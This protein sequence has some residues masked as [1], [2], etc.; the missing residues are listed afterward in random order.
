MWTN[1]ARII[2]NSWLR[3]GLKPRS[4]SRDLKWGIQVPLE[5]FT[6]KVSYQGVRGNLVPLEG[7]TDQE[8]FKR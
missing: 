3:D 4:I 2:T 5:G 8:K 7:F 6:D 1:N